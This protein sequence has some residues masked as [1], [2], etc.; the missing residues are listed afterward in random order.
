[1]SKY[2][3]VSIKNSITTQLLKAV[4]SIY[5]VLTVVVTCGHMTQ[6]Y[7]HTKDSVID[8]LEVIRKTFELSLATAIWDMNFAQLK[9]VY[10]GMYTFPSIIGVK[11]LDPNGKSI[12]M[13]GEIINKNGKAVIIDEKGNQVK[14]EGASKLFWKTYP[15]IFI[16]E[17]EKNIV[18]EA[19]IYSSTNVVFNRVKLGFIIIL[20]NSIIKTLAL[21]FLF[22]WIA[23][24]MLS[25]PL[26]RLTNA[27]DQI[28]LDRLDDVHVDVK[29]KGRNEL[30]VLEDAFNMMIQKLA[31]S[32]E[33]IKK[34]EANYRNIFENAADG[35]FQC[36][37][38]GRFIS[39]NQA[40]AQMLGYNS[41]DHLIISV[42]DIAKQCIADPGESKELLFALNKTDGLS[43]IERQ[44]LKKDK[45]TF[46]VSESIR[47]VRDADGNIEFYE[48][49]VEDIT[50]RK[51]LTE[52][53]S[54]AKE[55]AEASSRAKSDFLLNMSHE[56][57][58]PLNGVIGASELIAT[59]G[60]RSELL[61]V[62][63]IVR[64]SSHAMLQTVEQILDYSKSNDRKLEL[65]HEPFRLDKALSRIATWFSHKGSML[66]IRL[67]YD[68]D[69]V[70]I[71]AD[72]V[73]DEV[74]FIEILNHLLG[75]A[76]KFTASE[77][78]ATLKIK[79]LEKSL[80]EVL[81][82]F[83]LVDNGIGISEEL[84]LKI[85]E[86]FSQADTSNTRKYD[87]VGIGL[88]ICKQLVEL[89]GGKIWVK[90]KPGEGSVFF[91]TLR[92]KQAQTGK[93][94]D[95]GLLHEAQTVVETPADDTMSL[96]E[97]VPEVVMPIILDLNKALLESDPSA[98]SA[99]LVAFYEFNIPKRKELQKR[100]DDYEF[101]EASLV[102]GEIAIEIGGLMH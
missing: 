27:A 80:E 18:G 29:T 93:P 10:I 90:S 67:N 36:T 34:S 12:G 51:E 95:M 85:F 5:F 97:A 4:F 19:T 68:F 9:S 2:A 1:M 33:E 77:P 45:T 20:A 87:G 73:G 39:A 55:A 50:E 64:S 72:L 60:T 69:P 32:K 83:S 17:G 76:A 40:M 30:K 57:R 21:W 100:L 65:V 11:I 22:L 28:S 94:F 62:Q 8:E 99:L 98:I 89:M 42:T 58:T 81:F 61:K 84:H 46:W 49:I 63:E 35:I 7:L 101:E 23:R 52:A 3:K 54:K 92:F 59:S 25:R 102:L 66:A 75:N 14:K 24:Y 26:T 6:D 31:A 38:D 41:P 88:S 56:L 43:G 82:E 70:D 79:V 91:F 53:T 16:D 48:G 13:R 86:P 74:R 96:K 78:F 37:P 71:P 44:L 47:V 15:I